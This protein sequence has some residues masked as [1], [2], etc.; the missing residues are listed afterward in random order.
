[1]GTILVILFSVGI[2]V[3][4][5]V[6]EGVV[7]QAMW[8]WFLVPLGLPS[9]N[10]AMAVGIAAIIS[11]VCHQTP[12]KSEDGEEISDALYTITN[13]LIRIFILLGFAWLVH[14]WYM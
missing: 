4:L 13:S 2:F 1:M 6:L 14:R 12:R 5:S 10:V 9:I 7:L 8:W 11:L 3:G